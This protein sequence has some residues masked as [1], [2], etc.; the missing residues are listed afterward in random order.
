LYKPILI[1]SLTPL[2]MRR[3]HF[4]IGG[5]RSYLLWVVH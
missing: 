1:L 5:G 3:F 4:R 2:L